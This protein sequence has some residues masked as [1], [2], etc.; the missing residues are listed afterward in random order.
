VDLYIHSP[1]Q[2]TGYSL[3][4]I[5]LV[6]TC[7]MIV[8]ADFIFFVTLSHHSKTIENSISCRVPFPYRCETVTANFIKV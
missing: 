8:R 6:I 3:Y 4:D 1:I 7:I 2:V 5:E